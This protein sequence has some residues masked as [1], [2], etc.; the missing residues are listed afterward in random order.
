LDPDA[1][2]FYILTPVPGT[3]QY[4]EFRAGGKIIENNLDRFDGT[5]P[6]WR[7]DVL[8]WEKL[9][10]RLFHCYRKFYSASHLFRISLAGGRAWTH[11]IGLHLFCRYAA[12]RR[13]HPMSGGFGRV[14][15]DRSEDYIELR[16]RRF[17]LD[18]VPLPESLPLSAQDAA[19]NNRARVS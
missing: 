18:L 17:G 11:G 16:R 19:L 1:A 6:V 14:S 9:H 7:H 15:L 13:M 2:S 3:Q 4:D 8:G 12:F 10:E 5:N